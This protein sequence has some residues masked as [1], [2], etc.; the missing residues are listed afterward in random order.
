MVVVTF[1]SM[2]NIFCQLRK[3]LFSLNVNDD[4]DDDISSSNLSLFCFAWGK[5]FE[6]WRFFVNHKA[7]PLVQ[8][9]LLL[10]Q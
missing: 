3:V 7:L 1:N 2:T 9:K 5:V 10:A 4:D 8:L 6:L